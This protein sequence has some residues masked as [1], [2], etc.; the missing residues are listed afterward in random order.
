MDAIRTYVEP[1]MGAS[2]RAVGWFDGL[3][4]LLLVLGAAAASAHYGR[5]MHAFNEALLAGA[6]IGPA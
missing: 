5:E 6:A 2:P 4:S 1:T 3:Y